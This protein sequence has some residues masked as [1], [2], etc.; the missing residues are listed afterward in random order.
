MKPCKECNI[1]K[2]LTE[3]YKEGRWFLNTCNHC[4]KIRMKMYR[5]RPEVKQKMQI[6][7]KTW[8]KNNPEKANAARIKSMKKNWDRYYAQRKE[9][10]KNDKEY[11]LKYL[12]DSRSYFK[13]KAD[14]V[15]KSYAIILIRK[16][17]GG[18]IRPQDITQELIDLKINTV[19]LKRQIKNKQSC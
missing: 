7:S 13:R 11:K 9:R 12:E 3:Y 10:L 17:V 19:K 18:E 16:Q 2:P 15:E 8:A 5:N 14:N 1:E 4:R 6:Q